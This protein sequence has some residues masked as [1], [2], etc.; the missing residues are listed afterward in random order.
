[1]MYSLAE[2]EIIEDTHLLQDVGSEK[3][4]FWR[5]FY[6]CCSLLE[7]CDASRLE[8]PVSAM[9]ASTPRIHCNL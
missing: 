6:V 9:D 5:L 8:A 1:M 7:C 2:K 3:V 4:V